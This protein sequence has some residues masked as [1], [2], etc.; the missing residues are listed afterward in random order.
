MADPQQ[1]DD[2][3]RGRSLEPFSTTER[4]E[5][6]GLWKFRVDRA[7]ADTWALWGIRFLIYD[8]TDEKEKGYDSDDEEGMLNLGLAMSTEVE[9]GDP[10]GDPAS[11]TAAGS[12]STEVGPSR[13]REV[14]LR[15]PNTWNGR[16]FTDDNIHDGGMSP[17][18]RR[19][20][21]LAIQ[22]SLADAAIGSF[23]LGRP[24][25][26][27][28]EP[29]DD[30]PP[31]LAGQGQRPDW[32]CRVCAS[33]PEFPSNRKTR[34]F[35]L[36]N[37]TVELPDIMDD[38]QLCNICRHYVAV[39]YC[40][41]LP[42][43]PG[44]N[45]GQQQK[46]CRVR[47]LDGTT[48]AARALDDVLDRAVDFANTVGFRMIWV[49]QECLPQPTEDSPQEDK[50]YQRIGVR[51]MD[52]VYERALVTAG[53]HDGLSVTQPQ[54][55]AFERLL[56]LDLTRL[57]RQEV[58]AAT[59]E[60][61]GFLAAV[62]SERCYT[63]AWVVQESVGADYQL[64]LVFRR[65]SGVEGRTQ[66]RDQTTGVR[67]DNRPR[68]NL[69]SQERGTPSEVVGISL[70]DFHRVL[71]ILKRLWASH[72]SGWLNQPLLF[73]LHRVIR[74]AES[75]H[76][77]FMSRSHPF[78]G[79]R[80]V[81]PTLYDNNRAAISAATA[82]TLLT[83]REC[84]DAQDRVAIVANLC[85]YELRVDPGDVMAHCGSLRT[86]ILSL[87]LL[88]SDL[89]LLVPEM[90][91]CPSAQTPGGELCADAGCSCT[92]K[93]TGGV[94][95]P[96]DTHPRDILDMAPR[97]FVRYRSTPYW[98]WQLTDPP[99]AG[100]RIPAYTWTVERELNLEILRDQFGEAW[101]SLKNLQPYPTS[102]AFVSDQRLAEMQRHFAT[103]ADGG[104]NRRLRREVDD[105]GVLP[106]DSPLW[107]EFRPGSVRFKLGLTPEL[108]ERDP[109]S[110]RTVAEVVFGILRYLGCVL[111]DPL[112]AGL[113]DGIW[114]SL[115][116][117]TVSEAR[118]DLPDE[119]CEELFTHP[120]VV[121]RPFETL[122]LH[123][124]DYKIGDAPGYRQTW[125]VDR[126]MSTG[127]LWVGGYNPPSWVPHQEEEG[128]R[129]P[130][131]GA[132][133]TPPSG[134]APE[135]GAR[136]GGNRTILTMQ[137]EERL[138]RDMIRIR[139][140]DSLKSTTP[141]NMVTLTY[142][143]LSILA[144]R[145]QFYS[146]TERD[147]GPRRLAA[148]FEVNG[149]CVVATPYNPAWEVLPSP[150]IRSM[151]TCWAAEKEPPSEEEE[152][153]I[154]VG[155]QTVVADDAEDEDKRSAV[156]AQ[157]VVVDDDEGKDEK[158]GVL[159][160]SVAVGHDN[161]IDGQV[162]RGVGNSSSHQTETDE[163]VDEDDDGNHLSEKAKGKRKMEREPA[164]SEP[165]KRMRRSS[166]EGGP[167]SH[168]YK[169]IR[170]VRGLWKLMNIPEQQH[171]F[172]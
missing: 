10:T 103:N 14:E 126:I 144:N 141:G 62:T 70:L 40:W 45:Q 38:P 110:R 94:F 100:L 146:E 2:D 44:D 32:T 42:P 112:A 166:P 120:E 80:V 169:V 154:A 128:P 9:G 139:A 41:P 108:I 131:L 129:G 107:G 97:Q 69:D 105:D 96:F 55:N 163:M 87:S 17:E 7:E 31:P 156:G 50:D 54:L 67:G 98:D 157:N 79:C 147:Q 5:M 119:V 127:R 23:L 91:R 93:Y 90:Y 43:Q 172:L 159:E 95:S 118:M 153:V 115:R 171:T 109:E 59:V 73:N 74:N 21:K 19:Q 46:T 135:T 33:I 170:K 92:V 151:S 48:R 29:S 143:A 125:F 71:R 51:A 114:Q 47:D 130:P 136:R 138:M 111:D 63:R 18:E 132:A 61:L 84:R 82:L 140:L 28:P 64:F 85:R 89:S 49:D 16:G 155:E 113:A 65:T 122:Q 142:R 22:R 27:P 30:P 124:C 121:F 60:I 35:R 161:N 77:G 167:V 168:R 66:I 83:T 13:Q 158:S 8:D 36:F 4:L 149:P 106:D 162:D 123:R 145:G 102:P 15:D 76:P 117:D 68:H 164:D 52:L 133:T 81:A 72:H 86:G 150:E 37:P 148:A 11:G 1:M 6:S 12:S 152:D 39:S 116:V 24:Q 88:N 57:N 58:V 134:K 104:F 3:T 101:D 160:Q 99:S 20:L 34:K 53:L 25:T 165:S 26:P 78:Q 75:I 137:M 56:A